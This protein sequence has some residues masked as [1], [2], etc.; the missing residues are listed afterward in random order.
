MADAIN[1]YF[2]S[3]SPTGN[4]LLRNDITHGVAVGDAGYPLQ[5]FWESSLFENGMIDLPSVAKAMEDRRSCV[6]CISTIGDGRQA[7]SA[8]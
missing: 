1:V 7:F 6:T 4:D 3:S 5:G 2:L 8:A